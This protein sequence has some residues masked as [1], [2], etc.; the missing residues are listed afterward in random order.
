VKELVFVVTLF[1]NIL[2]NLQVF[3]Y[4]NIYLFF[5]QFLTLSGAQTTWKGTGVGLVNTECERICQEVVLP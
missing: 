1:L 5:P 2:M 4:L 3:I